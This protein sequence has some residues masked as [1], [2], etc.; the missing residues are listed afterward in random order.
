MLVLLHWT[1]QVLKSIAKWAQYKQVKK[2]W[3]ISTC[4]NGIGILKNTNKGTR[5]QQNMLPR[6]CMCRVHKLCHLLRPFEGLH[7]SYGFL[8][9]SELEWCQSIVVWFLPCLFA[10]WSFHPSMFLKKLFCSL[11]SCLWG[12]GSGGRTVIIYILYAGFYNY[13]SASPRSTCS[14]VYTTWIWLL[15]FIYTG[16]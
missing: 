5:K 9:V 12:K 14:Y 1:L 15:L 3:N 6:R 16:Y 7:V 11:L 8:L 10:F 2:L 4:R 13:K